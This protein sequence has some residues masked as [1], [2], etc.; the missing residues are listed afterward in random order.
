MYQEKI[1]KGV[2]RK[3][4][5][6]KR[7]ACLTFLTQAKKVFFLTNEKRVQHHSIAKSKCKTTKVS[8][9]KKV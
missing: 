1:V 6:I 8:I 4:L 7:T 3:K 5:F 9:E 2:L